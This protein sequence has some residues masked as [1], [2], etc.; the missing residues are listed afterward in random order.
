MKLIG[1]L[2]DKT[3][4][5]PKLRLNTKDWNVRIAVRSVLFD[6]QGKVALLYLRKHKIYKIPGGGVEL[7][8][9]LELALEREIAEETGCRA[10]TLSDLG[11]F[12]EQKDRWEKIQIS[13]CYVSE[14]VEYGEP[15][16]TEDEIADGFEL[17]WVENLK[18]AIEVSGSVS[19][20][21]Y[22]NQYMAARDHEI[23]KAAEKKSI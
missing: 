20:K 7:G 11:A 23:L 12:V 1:L 2:N 21:G 4:Q 15:D 18:K 22:G 16:F 17:I 8:E 5:N 14:V 3:V 10:K 9:N 19:P 6:K 13:Y